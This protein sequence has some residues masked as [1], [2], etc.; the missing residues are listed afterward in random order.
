MSEPQWCPHCG[1]R[2]AYVEHGEQACDPFWRS[3]KEGNDHDD[4]ARRRHDSKKKRRR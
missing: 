1:Q 2:H 4:R 3:M